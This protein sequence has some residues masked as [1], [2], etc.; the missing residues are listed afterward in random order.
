MIDCTLQYST[1]DP[2]N[3][4]AQSASARSEWNFMRGHHLEV[5][6]R[7]CSYWIAEAVHSAMSTPA[8]PQHG[9]F[10]GGL[11]CGDTRPLHQRHA[12]LTVSTAHAVSA[13]TIHANGALAQSNGARGL[14]SCGTPCTSA[15][16]EQSG[17]AQEQQATLA[18]CG[19]RGAH[20]P[21]STA[22]KQRTAK[23]L[24][25]CLLPPS[26]RPPSRITK[27]TY[28]TGTPIDKKLICHRVQ[29]AVSTLTL[30]ALHGTAQVLPLQ[31]RRTTGIAPSHLLRA[32]PTSANACNIRLSTEI[33]TRHAVFAAGH[34]Q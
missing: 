17:Q 24:R 14:S 31:R 22:S 7:Q 33:E 32:R 15:R 28:A 18:R 5:S 8:I 2:A 13:T 4:S 11:Q 29:P 27:Y 21:A 20:C 3:Q 12:S 6:R 16:R 26:A 10:S 1:H 9:V 19:Q 25:H 23:P 34:V 30:P